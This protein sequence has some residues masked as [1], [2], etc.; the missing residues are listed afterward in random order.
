[1]C[2]WTSRPFF[3][4]A[5]DRGTEEL[6]PWARCIF[7]AQYDFSELPSSLLFAPKRLRAPLI[8][9]VLFIYLPPLLILS[10]WTGG[11]VCEFA[12]RRIWCFFDEK[13][14]AKGDLRRMSN[15]V[16]HSDDH[17]VGCSVRG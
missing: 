9:Q 5:L 7:R 12:N 4:S 10:S 8:F 16:R 14:K 15:F 17:A 6:K 2:L 13:W 3:T 1:M 11:G